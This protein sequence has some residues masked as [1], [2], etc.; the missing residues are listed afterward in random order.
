MHA[1]ST[2]IFCC[3]SAFNQFYDTKTKEKN[4]I[5]MPEKREKTIENQH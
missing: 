3:S 5:S 1:T 4:E 2:L